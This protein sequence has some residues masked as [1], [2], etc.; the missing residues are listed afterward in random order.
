MPDITLPNAWTGR[1]Y[2]KKL[3][4]YLMAGG[5]RAA[6]VWHRRGGKDKVCLNYTAPAAHIRQGVYWHML[7]EA[8]QA[9]KAIWDAVDE[10]T[11]QRLIDQAFP[12]ELR[13]TTRES[14]MF[15][16]F[17]NGSTWQ[18]VGSDNYDSLIGSPPIGVV[19]SEFAY[20]NPMAW[21][22]LSPIL[23]NN[24]G[25][26]I[27]P[28]T[29]YG[30]NH[31]HGLHENAK[32]DSEWFTEI[33]TVE[34][35]G[36]LTQAFLDRR[37]QQGKA[38]VYEGQL[39]TS[40]HQLPWSH[41]IEL[42]RIEVAREERQLAAQRGPE[43]AAAIIQQEYY[44]SFN[45]ATPGSIYGSILEEMERAT[46]PR[47]CKVPFNPGFAVDMA[48]DLGASEG[49]D[50]AIWWTQRIGRETVFI[51]CDNAAN[52]GIDWLVDKANQRRVDRKFNYAEIPFALPHDAG[53]PQP[54]NAGAMSFAQKLQKDYGYRSRVNVVTPSVAWSLTRCK[55]YLAQCV[56]D[57]QHCEVGLGALRSYHR[58]YDP[59][60]Q[61][62]SEYAV[63]DWSSNLADAFRT[64]VEG[65]KVARQL[66]PVS[67]DYFAQKKRGEFALHDEDPLG[68]GF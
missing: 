39:I 43:E 51:D 24:N 27:F 48:C 54:S 46:P 59:K 16:R 11:G 6:P 2:Q 29:P 64:H 33:L 62:Y 19:F 22:K 4:D 21:Q 14:D 58:K 49:N 52:V 32:L 17:H 45:A 7:P 8:S 40:I 53:H 44:C 30:R 15:I 56:F 57:A 60:R 18:V 13:A 25:W 1:F 66:Q 26:A 10:F 42:T 23:L 12:K 47:I 35:T 68:R 28:S 34:D 61:N 67:V 3:W 63:H 31:Y 50:M 38:Y 5:K 20:A 55:Q 37:A 41:V 9:R 65:Q 36:V